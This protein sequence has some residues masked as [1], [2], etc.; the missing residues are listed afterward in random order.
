MLQDELCIE[1]LLALRGLAEKHG[2]SGFEVLRLRVVRMTGLQLGYLPFPAVLCRH[3]MLDM[4]RLVLTLWVMVNS[5][6]VEVWD[7]GQR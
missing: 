3:S 1:E 6:L 4:K 7:K 2:T 5:G